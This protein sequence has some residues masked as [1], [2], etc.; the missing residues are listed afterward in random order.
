MKTQ[1]HWKYTIIFILIIVSL[2]GIYLYFAWNRYQDIVSSEAIMLA[3]SVESLLHSEHIAELSGNAEDLDKPEYIMIKRSLTRLIETTNPIRFAYLMGEKDGSIVFLLDAEPSDSPDYSPPGQVYT[4]ADDMVWE[5]FKLGNTVLTKPRTDRWGTW[6]SALVPI[7]DTT[8][9]KV[10]AVLGIDYSA[11]EWQLRLLKQ[12]IPDLIIIFC[13][14][15]LSGALLRIWIQQST[16]KGLSKK[17]EYNEALYH[18][19][20][21]QVPVGIAIVHDKSFIFQSKLGQININPMFER[22]LGRTSND[23]VNIEW[24]EITHPEDLQA[25][26][27]KFGQFKT[28]KINGYSLEKRFVRPD[29]SSIWTNMKVSPFLGSSNKYSMHLCLLEDISMRKA[30]EESLRESERSKA[31]LLSNFPG[32][33]YRCHYDR[34]LTMQYVSSGCFALTGYAPESLLYNKELSYNDLII[35]EYRDII[36]AELEGIAA[37]KLPFKYEYEIITAKGD[38][39]WVLDMGEGIFSEG[40][41]VEA[42]EGIVIDVSDRKAIENVLKYNYEHDRWTGLYNQNFLE[43]QINSDNKNKVSMKRALV[44]INLSTIQS[45]TKNYGFNYTQNLLK[46]TADTLTLHC[47]YERLLFNTYENLFVFYLK[48]YKA[49]NELLEF[50][51]A[52]ADGL[53]SL[54]MIERI[55]GGIGVVEIEQ[56][57]ERNVDQLMKKLLITSER[58]IDIDDKEFGICFYDIVIETQ[59]SREEDVKRELTQIAV[60]ENDSTLFLQYQPILDLKSNQLCGFEALARLNSDKL[61]RVPPLEFIPI[62]EK[63]KLI[64]PIGNKVILQAFRFLNKLKENGYGTINVSINISVIQLLKNDFCNNLFK[65]INEMQVSPE[66]IS[67][68]ITES[69][70]ASDYEKTNSVLGE[71]KDAGLHISIDDFGI[72]YSSLARERD[73]NIDCLKIDKS[74]TDKLLEVDPDKA[75]TSEIILMAHK[76]GHCTIAEGVE[77]DKQ[78]QYLEKNGCDKIQGYLISKPLDEDAAIEFLQKTN[79]NK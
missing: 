37:N 25:D 7:K 58:A 35:P 22:I 57:D 72:G 68:E 26:L 36:W 77:Y 44:G 3:Q 78:K 49:K 6:I 43:K 17:L 28:G 65:M 56:V 69:V 20:F 54:L 34:Q 21:D 51:E 30:T 33:A 2:S 52:I 40:G 10:I 27:E 24:T 31:V 23:L 64:I 38:R 8:N 50:C 9:G 79:K 60:D 66:N 16:L 67:L 70:F 32:M 63:T 11:S 76:L 42:L 47:T 5:P 15:A 41:E 53:E 19:V 18:S 59:I 55:G 73:L 74:F 48:D 46:K 12:M 13:I 62:A 61:G 14:F 39:K 1:P 71:L 75:I 29:G 45:L 4:E